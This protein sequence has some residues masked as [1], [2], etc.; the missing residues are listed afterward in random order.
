MP[1]E[2]EMLTNLPIFKFI[3]SSKLLVLWSAW[4]RLIVTSF[5][6]YFIDEKIPWI[7]WKCSFVFYG[8][9]MLIVSISREKIEDELTK[10]SVC[11][12]ITNGFSD[13]D[14]I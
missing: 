14:F 5:K 3:T 12:R 6:N 10:K 9:G 2:I 13:S 8:F 11:N 4:S 1:E 7:I